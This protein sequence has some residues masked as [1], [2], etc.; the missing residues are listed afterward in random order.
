[1]AMKWISEYCSHAKLILKVDDDIIGNLFILMRH[2]KSL[3]KHRMIK[4]KTVRCLGKVKK[5]KF[6]SSKLTNIPFLKI[7]T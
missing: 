6:N 7:Y 4:E 3:S 2:L 5:K 1:M